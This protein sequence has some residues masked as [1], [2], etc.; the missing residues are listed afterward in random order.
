MDE[1]TDLNELILKFADYIQAQND[2]EVRDMLKVAMRSLLRVHQI[3]MTQ[4]TQTPT[5]GDEDG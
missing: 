4:V 5:E 2:P 3:V 1:E